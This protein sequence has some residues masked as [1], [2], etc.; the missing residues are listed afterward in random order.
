MAVFWFMTYTGPSS[1]TSPSSSSCQY[2]HTM[3]VP[4]YFIY[5]VLQWHLFR[6]SSNSRQP[7]P[8]DGMVW[9]DINKTKHF[10]QAGSVSVEMTM[11]GGWCVCGVRGGSTA[12]HISFISDIL[13][14]VV[15]MLNVFCF[16]N[17]WCISWR[18]IC[19][20]SDTCPCQMWPVVKVFELEQ[21]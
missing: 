18:F 16:T 8:N 19:N 14:I 15:Q 7:L 12:L 10:H 2:C 5:T 20:I 13:G 9:W 11:V 1:S 17:S 4:L 3:A 6:F 21:P